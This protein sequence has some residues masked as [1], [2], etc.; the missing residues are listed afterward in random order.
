VTFI[1]S[2]AIRGQYFNFSTAGQWM[3]DE[4][5]I[6]VPADSKS[7]SMIEEMNQ[8]VQKEMAASTDGAEAEWQRATQKNGLSVFNATPTVDM[9]PAASGVDVIV[10]YVTRAAD[11]YEVANKLN[12]MLLDLLQ[13]AGLREPSAGDTSAKV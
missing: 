1:N 7:Y 3:W 12:V 11:R 9:R 13:G 8:A 10:R 6:N 2:F 5:K 4:I